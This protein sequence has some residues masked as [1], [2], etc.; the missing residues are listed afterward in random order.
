MAGRNAAALSSGRA[1][2]VP[3]RTTAH[4]RAGLLRVARRSGA[5]PAVEHHVRDHAAARRGRRGTST[6]AKSAL[7]ASERCDGSRNA[8]DA[9]QQ[10]HLNAVPRVSPAERNASVA[11]GP[12]VRERPDASSSTSRRR[13]R[14]HQA[15][16]ARTVPS[17]ARNRAASSPSCT[18][19]ALARVRRAEARR[20]PHVRALSRGARACS[21]TIARAGA[22]RRSGNSAPRR[23]WRARRWRAARARRTPA[24]PRPARSRDP[25]A[26]LRVGPAAQR[27]RAASTPTT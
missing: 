7:V 10:Q 3:P 15:G 27:A 19:A 21:T 16:R 4:R 9:W 6:T 14:G 23:T 1:A 17:D 12:R 2:R 26:V 18:S 11:H 5:L 24:S 13:A 20:D 25:R 22:E 8:S